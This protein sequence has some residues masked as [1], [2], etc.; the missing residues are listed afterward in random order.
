MPFADAPLSFLGFIVVAPL[1]L[2]VVTVYLHIFYGYWLELER[3]RC[4]INQSLKETGEQQIESTK[5]FLLSRVGATH[6]DL[7]CILLACAT[8]LRDYHLEGLSTPRKGRPLILVTG[9]VTFI[10]AFLQLRRRPDNRRRRWSPLSC[11]MLVLIMFLMVLSILNAEIFY[12]P[13]NLFQVELPKA[14]LFRIDL[15]DADASYANFQEADLQEA[16]LSRANLREAK[17][18]GANLQGAILQE[19]ILAPSQLFAAANWWEAFYDGKMLKLLE[20]KPNHNEELEKE[21]AFKLKKS[22]K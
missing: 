3:E 16:N 1:L 15:R 19:A 2:G 11:A 12:R 7:R 4:L 14:R 5:H 22:E 17:L 6:P 10:L 18:Q 20:L 21:L 13:L 9:L 8:G